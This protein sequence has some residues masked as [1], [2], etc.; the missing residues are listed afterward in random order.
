MP[1]NLTPQY[2]SA[3]KAYKAAASLPDKLAA[4][5]EM[6][7][8]LPKH[9]GAEKIRVNLTKR[10]SKLNDQVQQSQKKKRAISPYDHVEREGAGQIVL[11]G[12]PNSGK[13]TLISALTQAESEVADYPFSTLKPV[14]G[15][16][17][18]GGVPLQLIDL[19]PLAESYTEPFVYNL[20]RNADRL[21][22]LIDL[23]EGDPEVTWLETLALLE[24]ARLRVV[25]C[26]A[27]GEDFGPS[28]GVCKALVVGTKADRADSDT[29]DR[30]ENCFVE[31]FSFL[32]LNAHEPPN[33]LK[34]SLF[35]VLD[36]IRVY[37]KEPGKAADSAPLTLK[38]GST[39]LDLARAIHR[40]LAAKLK[41]SCVWGTG[42][43]S[44]QRVPR[45]HVLQEGDVVELHT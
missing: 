39:P 22:V 23:A 35:D 38:R 28:T 25:G 5:K 18:A 33:A 26:E 8:L 17:D 6:L 27:A 34:E 21:C 37:S 13:S 14:V 42:G 11:V 19:P 12:L 44:G 36:L 2:L 30:F 41:Y 43:F 20:I 32:A 29:L 4:L 45:D 40:E 3:E 15:M 31:D 9:K 16:V 24:A 10:L 1:A 7:A